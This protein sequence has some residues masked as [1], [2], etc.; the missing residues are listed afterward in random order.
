[1]KNAKDAKGMI[2]AVGAT[3]YADFGK[4]IF[5]K[6]EMNFIYVYN[7]RVYSHQKYYK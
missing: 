6:N 7:A 4:K 5:E 3:A 1:M 2:I